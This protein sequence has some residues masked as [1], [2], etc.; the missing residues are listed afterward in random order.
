M[1][2]KKK[3]ENVYQFKITIKGIRPPIWRRIQVPENYTFWDLHVA[4]QNAMD[5][6]DAHLH[7]FIITYPNSKEK[8]R[9][10][11]NNDNSFIFSHILPEKKQKIADFFSLENK[12][13]EYIYD[14]GDTWRHKIYLEKILSK[15]KNTKYPICIAGKRATPPEDCGGVWSYMNMLEILKDPNHPDYQDTISWLGGPFDSE[16]F[17]I[18]E[19][20]FEDPDKHLSND[21][22]F[23]Y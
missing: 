10:G 2:M 20:Y 17:D 22:T 7:E 15:E 12:T 18:K 9:I 14:F 6:D 1:Y 3:F 5:W 4:I 23:I 13:A 16:H 19:I 21:D 11:S 8:I